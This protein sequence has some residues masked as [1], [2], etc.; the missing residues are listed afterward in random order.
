MAL[1]D[2]GNNAYLILGDDGSPTYSG[3]GDEKECVEEG[4]HSTD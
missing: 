3:D 2:L 1:I 4:T